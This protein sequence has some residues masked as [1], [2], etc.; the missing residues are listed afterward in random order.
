M[1]PEK[2]APAIGLLLSGGLDSC[3]LLG[4]LLGH[5]HAVQPFY[6]RSQLVWEQVE[7]ES[8]E[9]YLAAVAS[10]R[11]AELVVLDLPLQDLYRQGH[12]SVTGQNSPGADSAAEAVY[13]PGRNALLV[14]KA[15][16]WCQLHGI[17][18]L[19]LGVLASNPFADASRVFFEQIEGALNVG[20]DD[21]VRIVRPLARLNKRQ[22]M[23]L[24]RDLPLGLTF[25]CI[26][27]VGG[28]HCGNCNKCAE[29]QKAFEMVGLGDPTE[30]ALS[31]AS[32]RLAAS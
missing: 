29:R 1:C 5:G 12:W 23:E 4:R 28:L 10:P 30:Y 25:S 6:V 26:S 17:R 9:R 24:G 14:I 11:L 22:V 13:L 15:A 3:I 2:R 27:P 20:Q 31:P 8:L 32:D 7:L 19:A 21:L 18:R 16:L